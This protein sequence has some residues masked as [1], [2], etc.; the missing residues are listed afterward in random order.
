VHIKT[1]EEFTL[2]PLTFST[3]RKAE[4][5]NEKTKF[6]IV[7]AVPEIISEGVYTAF[8]VNSN[9]D[10]MTLRKTLLYLSTRVSGYQ[11]TL[12]SLALMKRPY[13]FT[14][15]ECQFIEVMLKQEK[16]KDVARTMNVSEKTAYLHL[17]RIKTKLNQPSLARLYHFIRNHHSSIIISLSVS[18][19]DTFI[20]EEE[21]VKLNHQ[22]KN[23]FSQTFLTRLARIKSKII[24]AGWFRK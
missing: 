13:C 23:S 15:R 16:V 24:P 12:E 14:L 2:L 6:I 5:V 20:K 17:S 19:E 3:L 4:K 8:V 18:T 9:D 1:V 21:G 22:L 11:K 10:V 7:T